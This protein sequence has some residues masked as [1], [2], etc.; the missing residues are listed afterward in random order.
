M[1]FYR[2]GKYVYEPMDVGGGVCSD[3]AHQQ[4][5]REKQKKLDHNNAGET[6]S[7]IKPSNAKKS[8]YYETVSRIN[9]SI[10]NIDNILND[11]SDPEFQKEIKE[12]FNT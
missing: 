11:S 9:K 4:Q 3:E 8:C 12:I 2:D 6:G 10:S 5:E 1:G 7:P